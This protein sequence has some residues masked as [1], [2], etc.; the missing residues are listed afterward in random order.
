MS[1]S[2]VVIARREFIERVRSKWFIAITLLGPIVMTTIIV[3]PAWLGA[4]AALDRVKIQVVDR[5]EHNL[6]PAIV[7]AS[8]GFEM[9]F[10]FEW[11]SPN[12]EQKVLL[13]RI[14]DEKINGFLLI[15]KGVLAGEKAIYRGDNATNIRVG[16]QLQGALYMA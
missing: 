3:V 9:P 10:D 6:F 2:W 14:R 5:S 16:V 12:I 4:R 8:A 1:L 11:V 15:P 7:R 13:G